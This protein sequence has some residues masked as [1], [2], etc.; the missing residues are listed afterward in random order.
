MLPPLEKNEAFDPQR[1]AI[2]TTR[3]R[4]RRGRH[5]IPPPR[6]QRASGGPGVG[7]GVAVG[8]AV[9]LF[10]TNDVAAPAAAKP[11]KF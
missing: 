6:G 5:I 7:V 9:T 3:S 2:A 10:A 1:N 4:R 11:R 8:L